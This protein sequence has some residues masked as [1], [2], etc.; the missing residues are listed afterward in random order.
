MKRDELQRIRELI[1]R[2][3][4]ITQQ[5]ETLRRWLDGHA[6]SVRDW[7]PAGGVSQLFGDLPGTLAVDTQPNRDEPYD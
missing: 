6:R 1:S 5:S 2:A 3:D 7:P 4:E